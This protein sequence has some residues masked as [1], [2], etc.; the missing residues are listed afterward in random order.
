M[1][2][3]QRKILK[4]LFTLFL[5]TGAFLFATV[6]FAQ[7]FGINEVGNEIALQGGDP[8]VIAARIIRI[9]LGFLGVIALG[10][11]L[12]GGFVWMTSAGNEEQ[13][14]KAKKI[15]TSGI[16]GLIIIAMA[17][18]ITS[19]VISRL[20]EATGMTGG[21]GGPG[22]GGPSGGLPAD[23]LRVRSF[24]PPN[25]D[26][27]VIIN[28]VVTAAFSHTIDPASV[29]PDSFIVRKV[30]GGVP[31]TVV[32]GIRIVNGNKIEFEPE[33][34]C[35]DGT[36]KCFDKNSEFEIQVTTAILR[37]GTGDRSLK[38]GGLAPPCTSSF[39]TGERFDV[40]P[41]EVRIEYPDST[42]RICADG[43]FSVE[44]S[45]TD[46]GGIRYVD[47]SDGDPI[48]TDDAPAETLP[49]TSPLQY[50]SSVDWDTGGKT[51]GSFYNLTAK[52]FDADRHDRTSGGVSV[53]MR[54]FHCC[55][56]VLDRTE[57]EIGVDCGGPCGGCPGDSCTSDA[58]C[59][60]GVCRGGHCL[61]QTTITGVFPTDDDGVP[62]GA[63]GNYL[64]ITGFGFGDEPG[65]VF[66]GATEARLPCSPDLAWRD[67]QIIV[68]IPSG[69]DN[70]PI[71][72]EA[73]APDPLP[74]GAG[75]SDYTDQTNDERG[76]RIE[77]FR[78][79]TI[80]RPGLCSV[81]VSGVT[82]C[83]SEGTPRT[84]EITATGT[85]FGSRA[86]GDDLFFGGAAAGSIAE[87]GDAR[88]RGAVPLI[89]PAT[90]PVQVTVGGENSNPINFRILPSA[91]L[92]QILSF[93]PETGPV[94]EYVTIFGSNFGGEANKV[95]FKNATR[96][97]LDLEATI[98]DICGTDWWKN[99][100]IIVK[101]P[102][103]AGTGIIRVRTYGGLE[104]TTATLSPS[105]FIL[106]DATP[107]PGLCSVVPDNGP[108]AT[109]VILNGERFGG[110]QGTS[111]VNFWQN[112]SIDPGAT[113]W[114]D[115]LI[116][117]LVPSAAETGPAQ[118]TVGTASS[119]R[120]N[121]TV[122]DCR[123]STPQ[124]PSGSGQECCADGSCL[125][126]GTCAAAAGRGYYFWNFSTGEI[127][128]F[129]QVVESCAETPPPAP[130]PSPS[131]WSGRRGGEEAC[132]NSEIRARFTTLM[133]EGSLLNPDNV[134]VQECTEI[135]PELDPCS[136]LGSPLTGDLTAVTATPPPGKDGFSFNLT[137]GD[138]T[139]N[140][141]YQV[142]LISGTDVAPGLQSEDGFLLDGDRN[143]E[144]GGNYIFRFKTRNSDEYCDV[145]WIGIDPYDA[146]MTAE[147]DEEDY[148][149]RCIAARDFCVTLNCSRYDWAWSSSLSTKAAVLEDDT[150]QTQSTVTALEETVPH[151]PN[152]RV[153][154]VGDI[155][156]QRKFGYGLLTVDFSDPRVVEKWPD[157]EEACVNAEV[158]AR[159]NTRMNKVS[160]ENVNNVKLY[161]WRCG[162]G[163]IDSGEDCD[164]GG[165][166]PGD[167]CDVNCKNEGTALCA[168]FD[169]TTP[170]VSGIGE[171][172]CGNGRRERGE[173]C[174]GAPF[175]NGCKADTAAG[176]RDN[177]TSEGT[178]AP[179]C[180]DRTIDEGEDC[181]LPTVPPPSGSRGC[182][183][184]CTNGGTDAL[185]PWPG[186]FD[187][188]PDYTETEVGSRTINKLVL[189]RTYNLF[190][191]AWYRVIISGQVE[192]KSSVRMQA[193]DLN[194]D[195]NRDG[196]VDSY[197]WAFKTKS[198]GVTC[199][200]DRV[201]VTPPISRLTYVGA[202]QNYVSEPFGAPDQCSANGQRLRALSY[203]WDWTSQYPVEVANF[204]APLFNIYPTCGNGRIE[205]GEDCDDGNTAFHD[206][207]SGGSGGTGACLNEGTSSL[208][209]GNGIIDIGEDCDD[210][211]ARSGD[212]CNSRCLHEGSVAGGS[213]CGNYAKETGEDCDDGN[214]IA[215]DG[216]NQLCLNTGTKL[217][218]PDLVDP[219]QTASTIGVRPGETES[220]TEI[221]AREMA[222]G[223]SGTARL[224]MACGYRLPAKPCPAVPPDLG[225]GSDTCCY[226]KPRV[227]TCDPSVNP[228]VCESGKQNV[229]RNALLSVTFDKEMDAAS[230]AGKILIAGDYATCPE[231][232]NPIYNSTDIPGRVLGTWCLGPGVVTITTSSQ[233]I[234]E[235]TT[236][237][238]RVDI[239]P[240]KLLDGDK[241]YVIIVK[242]D[243]LAGLAG[244]V[245]GVK[246]T[247]G[248]ALGQTNTTLRETPSSPTYQVRT[249]SFKT[250][251]DV[252]TL[253][254]VKIDPSSYLFKSVI[255][256]GEEAPS[257]VAY[258]K[259]ARGNNISPISGVYSWRWSWAS[260]IADEN[261]AG[262]ANPENVASVTRANLADP[263]LGKEQRV[264]PANR[265]GEEIISATARISEDTVPPGPSTAGR[266]QKTGVSRV[267]VFLCENPWP[268]KDSASSANPTGLF[269]FEDAED[270][271]DF[272]SP[273]PIIFYN[274][275]TYFCRDQGDLTV[276][277]D[278]PTFD[279]PPDV[280]K[281]DYTPSDPFKDELLREYL[282]T[283]SNEDPTSYYCSL[284]G[285]PCYNNPENCPA[286][287]GECRAT[288][289]AI[290]VRIYENANHLTPAEWYAAQG[291]AFGSP[292][293]ITVD[294]YDAVQDGRTIYV[295]A[296]N[297][298]GGLSTIYT[299]IYLISYNDGANPDAV[300]IYNQLLENLRFNINLEEENLGI[301]SYQV[302]SN[303]ATKSCTE[304]SECATE[305]EPSAVCTPPVSCNKDIDCPR[306]STGPS[307]GINICRAPKEK[308]IRDVKRIIDL[309]KIKK[310]VETY[311]VGKGYNP[312]LDAGT[313]I[314]AFSASTWGSWAGV[315]GGELGGG[316]PTDPI[317][318]IVGCPAK[319]CS[320]NP[321][322]DCATDVDC[323]EAT[324][325]KCVA[326][327]TATCWNVLAQVYQCPA[328]SHIYQYRFYPD[329]GSYKLQSDFEYGVNRTD[330]FRELPGEFKTRDTC[331]GENMS[332]TGICGDG[333]I[334]TDSG[335]E[336]EVG[337]SKYCVV[338]GS[339]PLRI[340]LG[341]NIDADCGTG[342]CVSKEESCTISSVS[343][344]QSFE[345]NSATCTWQ[346][347]GSCSALCGDGVVQ[348]G[349]GYSEQCDQG[350][351]G[352]RVPRGGTGSD[353]QYYCTSG[354]TWMGGWCGNRNPETSYGERGDDGICI[355]ECP[356]GDPDGCPCN[357]TIA[358]GP[359]SCTV[360]PGQT[361]CGNGAYG[362]V[363]DGDLSVW[364]INESDCGTAGPCRPYSK[365]DC[366]GQS[367]Y[368]DD[369]VVNGTEQCDPGSDA[370]R[371]ETT[372]GLCKRRQM[373]IRVAP[374][375]LPLQCDDEEECRTK[376]ELRGVIPDPSGRVVKPI[377]E[378]GSCGYEIYTD[379]ISTQDSCGRDVDCG[380]TGVGV[381]DFCPASSTGYPQSRMRTCKN[382]GDTHQCTWNNWGACQAAG[383][384]G[385]GVKEGSEECDDGNTNNTDGCIITTSGGTFGTNNCK[386][387][388]CGDGFARTGAEVCDAGVNNGAGERTRCEREVRY[389]ETCNY[390]NTTCAT[391]TVTG[392]RCG[393]G[394]KNGAEVCDARAGTDLT[395]KS[396]TI[397]SITNSFFTDALGVSRGVPLSRDFSCGRSC[398]ATENTRCDGQPTVGGFCSSRT[399]P[400]LTCDTDANC[401]PDGGRCVL[402]WDR[403]VCAGNCQQSCPPTYDVH[404]LT[405]EG[406]RTS[407][408][409]E[410]N[411]AVTIT[412]PTCRILGDLKADVD[413]SGIHPIPLNVVFVTDR[414]GSMSDPSGGN[415][416]SVP[417]DDSKII[418]TEVALKSAMNSLFDSYENVKIG[419]VS[420]QDDAVQDS[421]LR[422]ARFRATLETIINNYHNIVSRPVADLADGF[423]KAKEILS[424]PTVL[425]E[426]IIIIM[427]DGDI[428]DVNL[429]EEPPDSYCNS[430][431]S[432][433]LVSGVCE[434]SPW[435]GRACHRDDE[436]RDG[437]HADG[438]CNYWPAKIR[439][440]VSQE[441]NGAKGQAGIYSVAFFGSEN[442]RRDLKMWSSQCSLISGRS[443][444]STNI[445]DY[446]CPDAPK[447]FYSADVAGD[448][449]DVYRSII[450]A[451]TTAKVTVWN[452]FV[453]TGVRSGTDVS[454]N[455]GEA[456]C[457][458]DD[459]NPDTPP[460]PRPI[461]FKIEFGG[462]P[463]DTV[464]ISNLRAHVCSGPPWNSETR[465]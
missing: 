119:N 43:A 22:G 378:G 242:G 12:Y 319:V 8:R 115:R 34:V 351:T 47:Y 322:N 141:W 170:D 352:G 408:D 107:S 323:N 216:C 388:I 435:D 300:N 298:S 5:I 280:A 74:D 284:S 212:G 203:N 384:C 164:D 219:Y 390:C 19:F 249:W 251:D 392:P 42:T 45:A 456:E 465:P 163:V 330:W 40:T 267:T 458:D 362:K 200:V 283:F 345:C 210:G 365:V 59:S 434:R 425:G 160:V 178:T 404:T 36:A 225:I 273:V 167:G 460:A 230:I 379:F 228:L 396:F 173:D 214:V 278:L 98:P 10:I 357:T 405:F 293:S 29:T 207:C 255:P 277:D 393:D 315:L 90:V 431:E 182:L 463:G 229:C 35:P 454:L 62:N 349:A 52:A 332:S 432:N 398:S 312:K 71:R 20:M 437:A 112:K 58:D 233:T 455:V 183:A 215:T 152:P 240:T 33:G 49:R 347:V 217:D 81:C 70:V 53:K 341:C 184:N 281:N 257:F 149:G 88:I 399:T 459:S 430:L 79:N 234:T 147:G 122:R 313:Y 339:D 187:I 335:E 236:K 360:R 422:D 153:Q 342:L 350:P 132:I 56:D 418:C 263:V 449:D 244:M 416:D 409:L 424:S 213:L 92:P 260:S 181:D 37:T 1:K 444:R 32:P 324:E 205:I 419:L 279:N 368:C 436:C 26:T 192:S 373:V 108:V 31:T 447:Y 389:G 44:A 95:Y 311:R 218:I 176:V 77:N 288:P 75:A 302:C 142:T 83:T 6:V 309:T 381:C 394:I 67:G 367:S 85:G 185:T 110:T 65:H 131:P 109:R 158:G 177:C 94:G 442:N 133:D 118:V 172:C 289:D 318:Q 295:A 222:S 304:D 195:F 104:A 403:A 188:H 114:S 294:G 120:V 316:L 354:C 451:I 258:P 23:N 168:G 123:T 438:F 86:T 320:G 84:T 433:P 231:G 333:V 387:S 157:C 190:S 57:G 274:F 410:N 276:N 402:S 130:S 340:G 21:P 252:C 226:Q 24:Y 285:T 143:G 69:A 269:P 329:D 383:T 80:S 25:R 356:L 411:E 64:T 169:P 151:P 464:R 243:N 427:S 159:F 423:K 125:P 253:S 268:E 241:N 401:L 259:D 197:S 66:F 87:W 325:G 412:L 41:P 171:N 355:E 446:S 72:V 206:G 199:A 386:N 376:L 18:G 135:N 440:R 139:K 117:T 100:Q 145:G 165:I 308:L 448:L 14:S 445:A 305:G 38:C 129:P 238:T 328:G 261:P 39:T 97:E 128:V 156:D 282:F 417:G 134:V 248:V 113:S 186:G 338:A 208:L 372:S 415:C 397:E 299:N 91:E 271:N 292:Q 136:T 450:E 111:A 189:D 162:N 348:R 421:N 99:D 220:T 374:G 370:T 353:N 60:G 175:P 93:E 237:K 391:A 364:C 426:R 232:S 140:T 7:D 116:R 55:N 196:T 380:I 161:L 106:N 331:Y 303:E 227:V 101:V 452:D 428:T 73:K 420:Y 287:S 46:D 247:K 286:G 443:S 439:C 204:P 154:I 50:L 297:D 198:E 2:P 246:S 166:V 262:T 250:G 155:P 359:F 209:C 89:A 317:N 462:A 54:E 82:P 377:C 13:L 127:P 314:R 290:G 150:Y 68:E 3:H 327:D 275:R 201:Q 265:N 245:E 344:R 223:K 17:F 310:S 224:T 334:N 371:S 144:P 254:S 413:L 457:F 385:N 414:S 28:V 193:A 239:A 9:A 138:F 78:A 137:S 174:D 326:F 441:A 361:F 321:D 180:G 270:S 194:Y 395:C 266:L 11:V 358:G 307:T 337:M 103:G 375:V 346:T 76:R 211:N 429:G 48:A 126:A 369:G 191:D 15:L 400:P 296:A 148:S 363:C 453:T 382:P 124:C 291:L 235:G 146:V 96:G 264:T 61:L 121:F 105:N 306:A 51:V 461:N 406:G 202:T 272:G 63:P 336:C 366:T 343:G 407:V 221:T 27:D 301:C 102:P 4:F 179:T 256:P 16:I 30:E